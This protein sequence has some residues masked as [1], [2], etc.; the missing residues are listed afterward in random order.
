[1][2]QNHPNRCKNE[3][4]KNFKLRLLVVSTIALAILSGCISQQPEV[5]EV[6]P[7]IDLAIPAGSYNATP[8][9]YYKIS[10]GMFTV[11][12]GSIPEVKERLRDII[13]KKASQQ[14]TF[15]INDDV[16]YSGL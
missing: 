15:S 11:I 5:P 3:S 6:N 2:V 4:S 14:S 8:A 7:E 10:E 1:M 12:N 9:G 16:N 13:N